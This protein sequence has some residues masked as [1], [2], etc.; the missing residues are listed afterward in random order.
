M[1]GRGVARLAGVD[2]RDPAAGP[3]QDQGCGQA[4][5]AAADDHDVVLVHVSKSAPVVPAPTTVVAI[6]GNSALE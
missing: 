5:G 4:G 6:S 1:G 3:G 2:D